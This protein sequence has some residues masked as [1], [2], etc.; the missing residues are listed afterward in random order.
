[1][2]IHLRH[3]PSLQRSP[4]AT[5]CSLSGSQLACSANCKQCRLGV[6]ILFVASGTKKCL[7]KASQ[8]RRGWSNSLHSY[9]RDAAWIAGLRSVEESATAKVQRRYKIAR[10]AHCS[11]RR[12][13]AAVLLY[14]CCESTCIFA[15]AHMHV[16]GHMHTCTR[17]GTGFAGS[18]IPL[19]YNL[20]SCRN[21][22]M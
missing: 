5:S 16:H 11:A 6:E 20:L 15:D 9:D 13:L 7:D 3:H 4:L 2:C 14:S 21:S 18:R 17:L 12:H 22:L 10:D 19:P 8:S 1:M